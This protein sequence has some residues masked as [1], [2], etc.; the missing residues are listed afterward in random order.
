MENGSTPCTRL[1]QA[2]DFRGEAA[3]PDHFAQR[4]EDLAVLASFAPRPCGFASEA[5]MDRQ[6]I[7]LCAAVAAMHVPVVSV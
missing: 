6:F 3:F 7:R 2:R 5:E 4:H 1:E